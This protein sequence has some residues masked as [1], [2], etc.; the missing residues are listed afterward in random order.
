MVAAA[1]SWSAA[2]VLTKVVLHQLAPLDLLGVELFSSAAVMVLAV[3]VRGR[4]YLPRRRRTFVMLG[5]L[6]P[7][8]SFALF[9]FGLARTG[10]ADAALLVAAES[11]FG[12]LIARLVLGERISRPTALLLGLGFTG[13]VLVGLGEAGHATSLFGDVLVLGGSLTA[14]AYGVGARRFSEGEDNLAATATQLV[15]AALLSAPLVVLG[16]ATGSSHLTSANASHL[17]GGVAVGLTGGALPFLAFN[18]AIRNL[19]V[20]GAGLVL[21]LIPVVGAGLA[22]LV[23]GERLGPA[24]LAGG[25]LVVLAAAGAGLAA[26]SAPAP[27][28]AIAC[29]Q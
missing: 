9:D 12:V 23:L 5:A 7:A 4:P 13:S 20:A 27:E 1:A 26:E 8:L 28:G 14:A 6:E 24:E 15:A 10:A 2:T 29:V 22:V 21:N 11:L 17:I 19:A 25:A 3:A 16:A 18:F